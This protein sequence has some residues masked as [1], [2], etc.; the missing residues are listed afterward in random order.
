MLDLRKSFC[1]TILAVSCAVIVLAPPG[2]VTTRATNGIS[3]NIA[4][5][6]PP[7][8]E[9]QGGG[10]NIASGPPPDGETQG[11]SSIA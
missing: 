1:V 7:D 5:G 11:G 2:A 8:G 6:P 9:T 4:S 3:I 10:P